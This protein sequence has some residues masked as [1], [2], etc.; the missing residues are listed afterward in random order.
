[1]AYKCETEFFSESESPAIFTS[2]LI[3]SKLCW[4]ARYELVVI[5]GKHR[6]LHVRLDPGVSRLRKTVSWRSI[7]ILS[8]KAKPEEPR[9]IRPQE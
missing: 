9:T 2:S 7:Q 6:R 8:R 4:P 1:M 5:D 3:S